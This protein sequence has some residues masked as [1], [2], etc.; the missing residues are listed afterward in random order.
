MNPDGVSP[1]EERGTVS[2]HP[3]TYVYALRPCLSASCTELLTN[4]QHDTVGLFSTKLIVI[5]R[6]F[7]VRPMG[8]VLTVHRQVWHT[9]CQG[10]MFLQQKILWTHHSDSVSVRLRLSIAINLGRRHRSFTAVSPALFDNDPDPLNNP[11]C[12]EINWKVSDVYNSTGV[13][14]GA[15]NH[16]LFSDLWRCGSLRI[17]ASINIGDITSNVYNLTKYAPHEYNVVFVVEFNICKG[18]DI[19]VRFKHMT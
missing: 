6:K 9:T 18:K 17:E 19:R 13:L 10:E 4:A 15:C 2:S 5:T 7:C 14:T 8:G 12:H 1:L 3:G 11:Q 16:K